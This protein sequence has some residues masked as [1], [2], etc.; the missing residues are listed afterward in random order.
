SYID[1]PNAPSIR[2]AEK[3]GAVRDDTA[4]RPDPNDLVYRHMPEARA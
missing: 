4:A 1:P 3:L 2:L